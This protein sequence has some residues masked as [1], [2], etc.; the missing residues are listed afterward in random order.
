MVERPN[1]VYFSWYH[2]NPTGTPKIYDSIGAIIK[3]L[4]DTHLFSV[5]YIA[6]ASTETT[7]RQYSPAYIMNNNIRISSG[8]YAIAN[9]LGWLHS[10]N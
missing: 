1:S 3:T 7:Y 10:E 6:H 9:N 2:G 5:E 4:W 8:S